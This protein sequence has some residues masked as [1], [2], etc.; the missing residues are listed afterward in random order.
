MKQCNK[1]V[2]SFLAIFL[3][4]IFSTEI[5]A[6]NP[7]YG[8]EVVWGIAQE[9]V[10]LAPFGVLLGAAQIGKQLGY[11]SL[12]E[13]DQNFNIQPALATHWE[14]PDDRTW[15][16]HLRKGV[17]F[18]DGTNFSAP[19]PP[20]DTRTYA[21]KRAHEYPPIGDQL[22]MLWHAIDDNAT[23]K[24]RYA[25]FHTAIKTVKDANPK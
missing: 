6:K 18:H 8:G 24:T 14:N 7:K 1:I 15:I 12:V 9:P 21:E 3:V 20:A 17:K 2:L 10:S 4:V 22:D 19:T 5:F 25:D 11:D 13:Y 23:L 16:F